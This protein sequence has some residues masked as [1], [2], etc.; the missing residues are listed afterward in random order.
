M[1]VL[2]ASR[3]ALVGE[4]IRPII[5]DFSINVAT[6]NGTGSQTSN[7]TIMRALFKM[8][9]P[10]N[11]KNLFPSN[12]QGL[13]TW[14]QIRVSRDGYIARLDHSMILV[15]FNQATVISDIQEL[16]SG[17]V[18]IVPDEYRGLPDRDDIIF[19][20]VPV[21]T[22]M[23]PVEAKGKIKDYLTNMVYVGVLAHLLGIPVDILEQA[24]TFNFGG[25]RRPIE[26]NMDVVRRSLEWAAENL[27]KRDPYLVE[28]MNETAGQI[29]ISGNEAAGI[30]A[31]VGGVT[32]VAWYP[33]TPSTSLVDAINSYRDQ[34]RDPDSLVVVQAEDELA[35]AGMIV[36]AGWAGGRAMTATSGPGI[37]L[38]A[39]YSGLSYFAE[40]PAVI[41]DIQRV[42]PS[43][44]LPTRTS[45][46]DLLFAYY[47]GHGDTKHV[48]LLPGTV[49]ECFDFGTTAFNLA[50]ELQTTVFVL[51]DLDLGMNYW[52]TEPF[53]MP[54]EPIKRGKVLSAEDVAQKGFARYKDIDGD[55]VTYRTLP[56]NENPRSAYFARG[57]GHN[58]QAAYSERPEDWARNMARLARKFETARHMVPAPDVKDNPA[59]KIGVIYY[60][61]TGPAI[62]E[63]HDRLREQSV[64]T[65]LLRL[66]ALP[67]N[68]DLRA[69]IERYEHIYI[70]E[71]NR[72]GQLCAILRN[73]LPDLAPK[74]RSIAYLDG[75]P[76]TA[77]FVVARLM[78]QEA[79]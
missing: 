31:L 19:Y 55:G 34:L 76:L 45:Q 68:E 65:A 78:E 53:A 28:P 63:A 64:E 18:C 3:E 6:I 79:H 61:T 70:L 54:A 30:G 75:M 49:K 60:G 8:G 40:V 29:M 47:L 38:M 43:T 59:A 52:L 51:S 71:M 23:R 13:P 74:L 56:G 14:F 41:W 25:K 9:I 73:E 16:P 24:I 33:I 20:R 46:G 57:T 72:D 4:G 5:N 58:E 66:R 62:E 35:A 10:V 22:L 7:L 44:G 12:I 26:S 69:F 17:G 21:N 36:G 48:V 11:G 67:F 37:S 42:G 1:T 32:M 2:S 39:E 27:E 15:A 77:S 50:E